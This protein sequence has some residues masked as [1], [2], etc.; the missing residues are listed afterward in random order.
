[1]HVHEGWRGGAQACVGQR[2]TQFAQRGRPQTGEHR[3]PAHFQDAAPF[4]QHGVRRAVPVHGQVRPD[5]LQ[6]FGRQAGLGQVG[7]DEGRGRRATAGQLA[8]PGREAGGRMAPAG[9]FQKRLAIVQARVGGLGIAFAQQGQVVARAA[10]R[11]QHGLRLHA[12]VLQ[13]PQHAARHLAI[14]ELGVGQV[15]AAGELPGHVGADDG[16]GGKRCGFW[17]G[18]FGRARGVAPGRNM[19]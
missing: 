13:A 4:R 3:Q 18:H 2:L 12:D 9:L 17:Q 11:I 7:V 15:A 6:R 5:Q 8:D 19:V 10:A 14:E 1:M 16:Q